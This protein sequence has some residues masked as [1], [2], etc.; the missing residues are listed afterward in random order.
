MTTLDWKIPALGNDTCEID[1]WELN[2]YLARILFNDKYRSE[3]CGDNESREQYK[4][5]CVK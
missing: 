4:G 2:V 1:I 5:A 3:G